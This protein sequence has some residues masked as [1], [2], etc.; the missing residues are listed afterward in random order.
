MTA[1]APGAHVTRFWNFGSPPNISGTVE[2]RNFKFGRDEW[3]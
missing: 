3:Q 2:V 1:T